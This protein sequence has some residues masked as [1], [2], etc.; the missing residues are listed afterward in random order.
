MHA[1]A[2]GEA[3]G[4]RRVL[5]V[6]AQ[7]DPGRT[8]AAELGKRVL[9]ERQS[10]AATPPRLPD[11]ER[12]HPPQARIARQMPLAQRDAGELAGVLREEPQLGVEARALEG[13]VTPLLAALRRRR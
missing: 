11:A 5:G 2:A 13:E 8:P 12:L 9:E 6:D 4:A 1:G 3:D 7:A 10:E